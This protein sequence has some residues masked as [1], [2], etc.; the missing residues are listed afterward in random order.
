VILKRSDRN[1]ELYDKAVLPAIKAMKLQAYRI[2]EE[3]AGVEEMCRS[4]ENVQESDHVVMSLDDWDANSMFLTGVV[5]GTGRRLALLQGMAGNPTPVIGQM[6]H[7]VL[8]Y[9]SMDELKARL[10]DHF[11]AYVKPGVD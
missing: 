7:D 11:R 4:C 8:S 9:E 3:M 6:E 1:N 2:D 5:Y 10:M